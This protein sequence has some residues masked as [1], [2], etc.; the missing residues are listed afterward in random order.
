MLLR[1]G[2]VM[3]IYCVVCWPLLAVSAEGTHQSTEDSEGYQASWWLDYHE[4]FS[5]RLGVGLRIWTPFCLVARALCNQIVT[6]RF[7]LD[8]FLMKIKARV[9]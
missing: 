5:K 8:P 9:F 2:C 4:S 7:V 3:T 6:C 1:K